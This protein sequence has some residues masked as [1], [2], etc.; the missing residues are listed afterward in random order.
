LGVWQPP[1]LERASYSGEIL[2]IFLD[3]DRIPAITMA[4][5]SEIDAASAARESSRSPAAIRMRRHRDRRRKALRC[6]TIEVFE[7]E[8]GLLVQ[9]GFLRDEVRNNPLEVGNALHRYFDRAWHGVR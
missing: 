8:I 9:R 6:V 1:A 5:D 3:G 7:S 2:I 4:Q